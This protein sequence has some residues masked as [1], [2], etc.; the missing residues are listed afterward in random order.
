MFTKYDH[1]SVH[2]SSYLPQVKQ[3]IIDG[4]HVNYLWF[5]FSFSFLCRCFHKQDSRRL[6]CVKTVIFISELFTVDGDNIFNG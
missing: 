5:P 3:K 4:E 6:N 1:L 2:C